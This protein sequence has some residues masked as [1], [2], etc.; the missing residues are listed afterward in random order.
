M[1]LLGSNGLSCRR[2]V[3]SALLSVLRFVHVLVWFP[4]SLDLVRRFWGRKRED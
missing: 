2:A 1:S 3:R 4:L